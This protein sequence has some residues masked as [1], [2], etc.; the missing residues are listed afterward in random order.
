MFWFYYFGAFIDVYFFNIINLYNIGRAVHLFIFDE[1]NFLMV[2][3]AYVPKHTYCG[4][5]SDINHM[6]IT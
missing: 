1:S 3:L 6:K 2:I 4:F 5:F